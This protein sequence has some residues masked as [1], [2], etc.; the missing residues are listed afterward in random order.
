MTAYSRGRYFEY[1]VRDYLTSQGWVVFRSAGSH[2]PADLIAIRAGETILVQCRAK[3]YLPPTERAGFVA[4][5]QE[6]EVRPYLA[7]REKGK[8]E[9]R[10]VEA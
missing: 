10:E 2:S 4:V 5:A 1:R 3:G 7:Y 8:V 6:L 9:L